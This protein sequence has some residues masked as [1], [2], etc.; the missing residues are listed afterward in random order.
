MLEIIR[1]LPNPWEILID[2]ISLINLGIYALLILWEAFFPARKLPQVAQWKV[3]G[4]LSFALFFYLS[5]YF[6]MI[7]DRY[8]ANFQ[9]FDLTS[10]GVVPGAFVALFIYEFGVYVWHRAMHK[11]AGLWRI[12]HQ[13]HHSAERVDSYGAFFFSPMDMIGF[14]L[15]ASLCLVVLA[16]FS[17]QAAT[18]F[19]LMTTFLSIFQHS[20]IKTPVWLGYIIQRPESHAIH[21]AK[22]IHAHNYSDLPIFDLLFGTFWNPTGYAH[23]TGF[24]PGA[25][26]KL[27]KMLT[28][29]DISHQEGAVSAPDPLKEESHGGYGRP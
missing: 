18:L 26:A 24:Y 4:L 14:S 8:L 3:R 29:K 5:T 27:L 28:F 19:I 23:E 21:H 9:I 6:P 22:G 25:S 11:N 15:L 10:L 16:G 12:F 13:M 1:E 7:W 20:N 17:A 2:P